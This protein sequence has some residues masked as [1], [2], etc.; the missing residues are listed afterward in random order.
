MDER[1]ER[2]RVWVSRPTFADVIARLEPHCDVVAE[3]AE[4]KFAPAELAA[5]LAACD[6]A[7]VGLKERIGAAEVA[8][9]RR[10]RIVA[11]L[12]VGYDNLDVPALSAAGIVVTNTADVLNESV[13]DFAWALLLGAARRMTAAERWLRA[14]HW[15]ATEFTAWLG[16]DLRERTLGIFGMGRI[17]QAI[18]RRAGGFGLRVIYHNRRR[19]PPE[20]ERTCCDAIWVTREALLAE[21]DFLVLALPLTP[22]TRHAIGAA[23]LSRMKPSAVLVNVARGGIVDDAA[24]AAAL[25][26]GRLAAAGLDVFEGEPNLHPA[27]LALDNV[28]LCPHIASAT[29]GTRRAMTALAVTNVLAFFGHGEHAGRPPNV[30]NP[31][32]LARL[33]AA[34]PA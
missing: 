11:N 34:K 27:L 19:L 10:L 8:G 13:A 22:Q 24:L 5:K 29:H 4:V 15:H 18:A 9:A 17:G 33:R 3:P 21:A 1:P 25:A 16:L 7:I 30:V 28:V 26:D 12:A 20:L 23:E 32:V 2:P 31:E 6:A 14:G